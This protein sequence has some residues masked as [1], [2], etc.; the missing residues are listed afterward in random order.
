MELRR[1]GHFLDEHDDD[2]RHFTCF[3]RDAGELQRTRRQLRAAA[4]A[5]L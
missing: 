1:A 4:E 2:A 5:N 3:L